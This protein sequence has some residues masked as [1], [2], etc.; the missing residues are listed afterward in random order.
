M[1]SPTESSEDN[2]DLIYHCGETLKQFLPIY[3]SRIRKHYEPSAPRRGF[4]KLSPLDFHRKSE[5]A[6][7]SDRALGSAI[8]NIS[9]SVVAVSYFYGVQRKVDC[10]G[11]II[12]WDDFTQVATV[13]TSAKLMRSPLGRDDYYIIVRLANGKLLEA[14][15]DYVDYY[16]NI[17]TF[18]VK[19]DAKLKPVDLCCVETSDGD[20]VFA[21]RRDFHNCKLSETGGSIHHDHPY[22]GCEQLLS[23]T[24][25]SSQ[26][27]EGGPLINK[28]GIVCGINFFDGHRCV[29]PLPT[30]VIDLCL[31]NWESYGIVMRPWLGFT[32]MDIATLPPDTYELMPESS[33]DSTVVVKEVYE[34]SPADKIEVCPGDSITAVNGS[35][36][37]GGLRVYAE[38][39]NAA[40]NVLST[41]SACGHTNFMVYVKVNDGRKLVVADNLNVN[42]KKFCSSWLGDDSDWTMEPLIGSQTRA[43]VDIASW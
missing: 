3:L 4:P 25:R 27:G 38:E 24:C 29:H 15:E 2:R 31:R 16:H 41:L 8:R 39:L 1:E 18:K 35:R 12:R 19:S 40:S 30:S 9:P 36:L 43:A 33:V 32:V 37:S 28:M 42:D 26:V 14:V 20:E 23:S 11:F 6:S 17:A 21:L 7:Y 13:L 10:S 22:F 5:M 34:G